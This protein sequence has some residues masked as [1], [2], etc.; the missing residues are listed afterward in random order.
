MQYNSMMGIMGLK[1]VTCPIT[2]TTT[3]QKR[4]HKKKRIN[5]KLLKK[6]GYKIIETPTNK[7]YR[8]GDTIIMH[9]AMKEAL[10]EY[11]QFK[12]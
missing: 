3:E 12:K 5:K 4:K 7:V 10:K 2:T 9:P 8:M 1:V 6:Y 11:F